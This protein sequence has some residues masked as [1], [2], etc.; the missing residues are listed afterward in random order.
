MKWAFWILATL[1][2]LALLLFLVGNFGWLG[3]EK[4]PLSGVFLM[5]LGLPWSL[6]GDG[7]GITPMVIGLLSPAINL[8]ILYW[9]WKR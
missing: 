1:Y 3:Q 7:L 2:G 9:L 4:D 8:G 6:I 5:P